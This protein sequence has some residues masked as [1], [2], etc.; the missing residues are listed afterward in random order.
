MEGCRNFLDRNLEYIEK[1]QTFESN[2]CYYPPQSKEWVNDACCNPSKWSSNCCSTK[3]VT[4]M[5][6]IFTSISKKSTYSCVNPTKIKYLLTDYVD[7]RNIFLDQQKGCTT[8][9]QKLVFQA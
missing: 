6:D 5:G 8:F 9:T 7:L 3:N 1:L 4:N 2:Y